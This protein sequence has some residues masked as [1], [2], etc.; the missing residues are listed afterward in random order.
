MQID[1]ILIRPADSVLIIQYSDSAGRSDNIV[2]DSAGNSNISA[3]ISDA[4]KRVPSEADRPDKSEIEQEI[5]ELEY[6]LAQLKKSIG[7]A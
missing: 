6:R 3:V 1:Q 5:E 4:Q 2:V 7:E